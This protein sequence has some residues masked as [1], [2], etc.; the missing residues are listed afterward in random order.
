MIMLLASQLLIDL[1]DFGFG[2]A[3]FELA[4]NDIGSADNLRTVGQFMLPCNC[5]CSFLIKNVVAT[6]LV[7]GSR[8]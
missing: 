8:N 7:N 1:T 4:T 5:R 3:D 6:H 2:D